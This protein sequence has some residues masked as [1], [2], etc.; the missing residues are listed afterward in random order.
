MLTGMKLFTLVLCA[1]CA[2]GG[3]RPL[4][5]STTTTDAPGP[6]PDDEIERLYAITDPLALISTLYRC[7]DA[8][9]FPQFDSA[10]CEQLGG[11]WKGAA[12]RRAGWHPDASPARAATPAS[13]AP[14]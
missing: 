6:L 8:E 1:L 2:H 13:C 3:A 10:S 12:E 5:T 9:R 11:G 7:Y 14:W 4:F